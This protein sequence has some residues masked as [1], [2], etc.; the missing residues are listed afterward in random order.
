MNLIIRK[1]TIIDPKSPYHNKTVDVKITDGIIEEIGV[2]LLN[3][4]THE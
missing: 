1:A 4:D 2:S 3:I